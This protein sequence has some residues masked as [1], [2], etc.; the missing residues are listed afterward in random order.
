M[1]NYW[2]DE[3]TKATQSNLYLWQYRKQGNKRRSD[4]ENRRMALANGAMGQSN[5]DHLKSLSMYV[6]MD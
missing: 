1:A 6:K 4:E 2:E 3:Q 5:L